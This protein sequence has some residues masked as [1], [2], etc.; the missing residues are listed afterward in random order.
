MSAV[1][2]ISFI[3]VFA[4]HEVSLSSGLD[5]PQIVVIDEV[6]GQLTTFLFVPP[7]W[8]NLVSGTVLFRLLDIWKPYPIRRLEP[9]PKGVGIIADDLLAGVYGNLVL[10]L[11]HRLLKI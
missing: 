6:A 9:L 11:V 2:L 8:F 10:H 4:A 1:C 5:D 7:T 3:G